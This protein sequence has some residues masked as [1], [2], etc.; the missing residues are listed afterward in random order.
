MG[1]PA[2]PDL[3][4][5]MKVQARM[6]LFFCPCAIS[7]VFTSAAFTSFSARSSR[8]RCALFE[9]RAVNQR[10]GRESFEPLIPIVASPSSMSIETMGYQFVDSSDFVATSVFERGAPKR[11]ACR[12]TRA[13]ERCVTFAK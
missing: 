11:G 13:L 6:R 12:F 7:M 1:V 4:D 8:G 10:A 3:S 9:T 2:V 5:V